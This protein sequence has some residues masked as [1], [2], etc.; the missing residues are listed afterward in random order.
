MLVSKFKKYLSF[1]AIISVSGCAANKPQSAEMNQ[2]AF[3]S[4]DTKSVLVAKMVKEH[5][6][7][8]N[9]LGKAGKHPA[10]FTISKY[11]ENYNTK[12]KLSYRLYTK[13]F[14][15]DDSL[16]KSVYLIEP[17]TYVIENITWTD[18]N[19][20]FNLDRPGVRKG[21]V[22]YGAFTVA[23]NQVAYLGELLIDKQ[24]YK[25]NSITKK[26]NLPDDK[27]VKSDLQEQFGHDL[28]NRIENIDLIKSG[29]K[30]VY[31]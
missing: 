29:E 28:A 26:L 27:T 1:I 17:G 16:K 23:P 22:T 15:F 9:V 14:L 24:G 6:V 13:A 19:E 20:E 11:D 8:F 18:G 4:S 31:S 7:L 5:V 12:N 25:F 10:K 3:N 2:A 21:V 30:I